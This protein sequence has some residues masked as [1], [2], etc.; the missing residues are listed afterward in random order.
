[1][2]KTNG[3]FRLTLVAKHRAGF[4]L[5]PSAF[6]DYSVKKG[7]WHNGHGDVVGELVKTYRKFGLGVGIYL[8]PWDRHDARYGTTNCNDYYV[9]QVNE[10]FDRY[11]KI[12]SLWLDLAFKASDATRPFQGCFIFDPSPSIG[13]LRHPTLG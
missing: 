9:N 13:R 10:L 1:M 11:G 12:D 4:C 8:S 2:A 3:F 7:K 5:W 6:T